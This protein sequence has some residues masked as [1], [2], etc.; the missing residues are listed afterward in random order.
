MPE[1]GRLVL[2]HVRLS[3]RERQIHESASQEKRSEQDPMDIS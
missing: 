3:E 2:S 1:T